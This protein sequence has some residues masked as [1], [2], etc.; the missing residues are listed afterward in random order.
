MPQW[1]WRFNGVLASTDPVALDAVGW[2]IIE[3]QRALK[4]MPSLERDKRAP[5]YI[6]TAADAAHRLGVDDPARIDRREV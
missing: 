4:G 5:R 6:A 1:T 2:R 3:R